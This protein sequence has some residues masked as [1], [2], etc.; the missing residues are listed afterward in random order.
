VLPSC[1]NICPNWSRS[2]IWSKTARKQPCCRRKTP[3]RCCIT[4]TPRERFQK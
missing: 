4:S 2:S 3:C 1:V